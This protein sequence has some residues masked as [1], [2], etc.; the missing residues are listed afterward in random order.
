MDK[1]EDI[2]EELDD[3]IVS[4]DETVEEQSND[5]PSNSNEGNFQ[6]NLKSIRD[7]E[8]NNSSTIERLN[9]VKNKNIMPISPN[10]SDEVS[11]QSEEQGESSTLGKIGNK[12]TGKTAATSV[13]KSTTS[14]VSGGIENV[15][16]QI[17]KRIPTIYKVYFFVGLA[18][19][20]LIFIIIL[21]MNSD[22][23]DVRESSSVNNYVTGDMSDEELYIYLEENGI[24]PDKEVIKDQL[25][26]I[27]D[28][29]ENDLEDLK[30]EEEYDVT[31]VC[32]Y[33]ISYFKRIKKKYND[34][35]EEC[36]AGLEIP[37]D[38]NKPCGVELN[39]PLL[40]E[41]L[42]YGKS[43]SELWNQKATP[44]QKKDI[45]DLTNA[46]IE[47][48]HEY[49]YVDVGK[50]KNKDGKE[51]TGA[52]EGCTYVGPW[53]EN[54]EWHY[55]QVSFDKYVSFLKYGTSS[56]HP[57]YTKEN[58][59]K[60]ILG[61]TE[62]NHS[63]N[64]QTGLFD[65]ECVGPTNSTFDGSNSNNNDNNSPEPSTGDPI[66]KTSTNYCSKEYCK[67]YSG[68]AHTECVNGCKKNQDNCKNNTCKGINSSVDYMKCM[69]S[70]VK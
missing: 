33:A 4:S 32:K 18:A 34:L 67:S 45:D 57:Y 11:D 53:Y 47:Y 60:V 6:N 5:V 54:T 64:N 16:K 65:H 42:S 23:V 39:I 22:D 36:S 7:Y 30:G 3:E 69:N 12:L 25:G 38:V 55:F 58:D 24:C 41:T 40:H 20:S 50:Y 9:S 62:K 15:A 21:A 63:T 8:K 46:M 48:V 35:H 2:F 13:K 29:I 10:N 61:S 1:E 28:I 27:E 51:V 70:C 56:S 19:V 17:L 66:S 37:K 43:I 26:E 31:A 68:T 52:C 14:E 59:G 44:N 49:C